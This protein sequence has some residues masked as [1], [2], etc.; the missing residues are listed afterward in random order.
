MSNGIKE[1]NGK[2]FYELDWY[3]IEMMAKRMAEN[4]GDKY[5]RF[6]WMNE[7]NLQE[8]NQALIRHFMEVQKGNYH[9]NGSE[10]GH[11]TALACNAM[12]MIYQLKH[13]NENNF[14]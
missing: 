2:L 13:F 9:D 3:F 7:I 11:L 10:Y 14:I 6:N 8:L 5:P 4:K 1:N 12:M